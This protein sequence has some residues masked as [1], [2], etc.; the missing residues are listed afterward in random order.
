VATPLLAFGADNAGAGLT[1]VFLVNLTMPVTLAAIANLLSGR[2]AFAFGLASLA[3]ELG[4]LPVTNLVA[5]AA[6]FSRPWIVFA[7][8]SGAAIALYLG[9][10][11]AFQYWPA[12]FADVHE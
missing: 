3:L 1:G 6:V 10:R 2:P 5:D 4:A 12:R 11:L 7:A 9:L 8:L